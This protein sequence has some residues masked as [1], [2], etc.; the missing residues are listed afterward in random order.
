MTNVIH[1]LRFIY[2]PIIEELRSLAE[3]VPNW[4]LSCLFS[5]KYDLKR[6]NNTF[7]CKN[8]DLGNNSLR[9]VNKVIYCFW[10]GDN[11]MSET[12]KKC[13]EQFRSRAG[14]PVVLVTPMN[15]NEYIL[16]NYPLH[17]AY[18]Y[19]S[20]VHKADYL[21]C[22]FMHHYGGGYGDVKKYKYRWNTFFNELNSSNKYALGYPE[23]RVKDVCHMYYDGV[24]GEDL[25]RHYRYLVGVCSFICRPYTP[26]TT[27][28]YNELLSRMDS[29]ANE[30][31]RYPGD[32]YGKNI[33]YPIR[34]ANILGAIFHPLSLKYND[35]I[36]QN[37]HI[38]PICK[39]YR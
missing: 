32:T 18:K 26:I 4:I 39:D 7:L 29:Y 8:E 3:S 19:L 5:Y 35:K 20:C 17:R 12:R 11:E 2:S 25:K 34:W 9:S 10:T 13:L 16:P 30:L 23:V 27:E 21:R 28:W 6:Y 22:Y 14:V 24:I 36:L 15:L 1:N 31:E 38:R 33:G 37:N